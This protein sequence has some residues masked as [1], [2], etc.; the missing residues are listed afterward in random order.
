MSIQ[1]YLVFIK[2]VELGSF[3]KAAAALQYTQ[4]GISQMIQDLEREWGVPLLERS[5]AGVEITS[6][7]LKLLPYAQQVCEAN[8]NLLSAVDDLHGLQSGIIRIATFP[9]IASTW[10]PKIIRAFQQDYP[11]IEYELLLG[12]YTEI[13]KWISDG[14]VDMGVFSIPASARPSARFDFIFLENDRLLAI[15]AKDHPLAGCDRFPLAALGTEP[16]IKLDKV[17]LTEEITEFLVQH[18]LTQNIRFTAWDN[19]T[20]MCMVENGLGIG[21][22]PELVLRRAP[23][24]IV[25]KELEIPTFRKLGIGLKSAK[26]PPR[27]A[28]KLIEYL[29]H[30]NDP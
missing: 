2:T 15:L 14:R 12:D 30:R 21:I 8:R 27:I 17:G 1:K 26:N 9:S 20:V 25:T 29:P 6:D 13:E 5:R 19:T 11:A 3:T 22:L 7:G 18:S 28:K 23:Y 16:F 24:Q 10:L 4:S